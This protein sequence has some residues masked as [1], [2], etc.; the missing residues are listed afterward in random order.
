MTIERKEE[1]L[2]ESLN[3][4]SEHYGNDEDVYRALSSI[5]GMTDDEIH[6]CSFDY[7]DEYMDTGK[8]QV[9][10]EL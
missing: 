1:L 6:E 10:G 5:L 9:F 8:A 2:N 3:L 7:L 4:I